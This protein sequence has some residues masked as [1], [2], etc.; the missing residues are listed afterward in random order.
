MTPLFG[1]RAQRVAA[2][3][4]GATLF[5]LG[6]LPQLGGLGYEHAVISGVLL[7]SACAIATALDVSFELGSPDGTS[8]RGAAWSTP[9]AGARRGVMSGI[10]FA[11]MGIAIGLI[12]GLRVGICDLAGGLWTFV[13]TAGIG[14]ILGGLWGW[15]AGERAIDRKRRRLAATVVALLGPL[16]GIALSLWRF[17]SSP[18]VFAYD[19]FF[20]FFNGTLYDTVVDAGG[21]LVTYRAGSGATIGFALVFAA[22][23]HRSKGRSLRFRRRGVLLP[24]AV[25]FALVSIGITV[26]GPALGHWETSETI[27]KELGGERSGERCDVVFPKTLRLDESA[28]LVKDCDEEVASAEKVLGTH[29]PVKVRAFFFRDSAEKRRL[30]G[31]ADT[32]IAKPWRNEVYLQLANYP[33]PVLGHEVAHVVAGNFGRGPFRIAGLANGW[34]PNPGLIEGVAVAASPDEDELTDLE[35]AAAMKRKD[36]LPAMSEIFSVDFLGSSASKS[37]TLAG[38]FIRWLMDTRG[39]VVVRAWYSGATLESQ[40]GK[41]WSEIDAEFRQALDRVV[42][43]P[44]ALAYV[45]SKFERPNVWT[46]KCPHVV[47]AFKKN[48]DACRDAHDVGGARDNYEKALLRD[49]HDDSATLAFATMELREGDAARGKQMLTELSAGTA[50]LAY[51]HRAR[52][53]LADDAFQHGDFARAASAYTELADETPDEDQ[54]RTLEVKAIAART[55]DAREGVRAL[56]LGDPGRPADPTL[57]AAR[58]SAWE[59][60]T[61]DGLA[62]YLLGRI[63]SQRND[64]TNAAIYFDRVL[65]NLDALPVRVRR[66]TIRQ[67]AIIACAQGDIVGIDKMRVWMTSADD[68]FVSSAGGRRESVNRL[69]DRCISR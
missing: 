10:A 7:P 4:S 37:Y 11:T 58:I 3:V 33:H 60:R 35:W 67:R 22:M 53:T 51:V 43:P 65:Q 18:M 16:G 1:S 29:Q 32:Y 44:A 57:A 30:M 64:L 36:K 49:R 2:L 50:P 6:F 48:G 23:L 34:W 5:G 39:S 40:L 14:T 62:S 28:L 20:G 17:Y 52:E 8:A 26:E 59:E 15:F 25:L 66:E 69:L 45:D 9:V 21:T 31:A 68:A 55:P 54:A 46:R 56:L 61:H 19:P 27:T 63:M 24:I 47:D 12:H 13:L 42:L 41:S 38:A